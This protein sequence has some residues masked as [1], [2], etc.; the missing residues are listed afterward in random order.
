M[1]QRQFS[2]PSL[3]GRLEYARKARDAL[4]RIRGFTAPAFCF[5]LTANETEEIGAGLCGH[6]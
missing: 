6:Y 4:T 1:Y 2:V 5:W 3:R